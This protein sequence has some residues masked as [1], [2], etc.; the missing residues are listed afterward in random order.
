MA[1]GLGLGLL[2]GC[3]D[4]ACVFGSGTCQGGTGT[5][6]Q[7][8]VGAATTPE[9]GLW[10]SD[11]VPVV[12]AIFP[13]GGGIHPDTPVV[14]RFSESMNPS[15][16]QGAF[17]LID[18]NAIGGLPL[19][20]TSVLIGAGR[21]LVLF[22][23]VSLPANSDIQVVFQDSNEAR[24]L[25]GQPLQA[26]LESVVGSF[27]VAETEPAVPRL[28][29][30][31][32]PAG[33]QNASATTDI[34]AVFDR[35]MKPT[36]FLS[37]GWQVEV[38]GSPPV[39]DPTPNAVNISPLGGLPITDTRAWTYRR[40]DAA[41]G[42][43]L[44]YLN[45]SQ[46][47][48]LLS[49]SGEVQSIDDEVLPETVVNFRTA[50]FGAPLS[51][52]IASA[53]SDAIGI[54]NLT[55]GD[56]RA[57]ELSLLL[58]GAA[59][60]DRV[61]VFAFGTGLGDEPVT[62]ATQS[63]IDIATVS[64]PFTIGLGQTPLIESTSPLQASFLDGDVDL[65]F[66]VTRGSVVS[67]LRILD[68]DPDTPGVQ[69]AFLDT[70][71]PT[72]T[73]L[74]LPGGGGDL[75]S[76]SLIDLVLTGS[77]SEEV[78]AVNVTVSGYPNPEDVISN[79]DLTG[80]EFAPVV[81]STSGG[82]F[83]AAPVKIGIVDPVA[84]GKGG[85]GVPSV[86]YSFRVYDRAL[87]ANPNLISGLYRQFGAVAGAPVVQGDPIHVEVI[88]ADTL[89]P[90]PGAL[91]V[92]GGYVD[93]ATPASDLE[94]SLTDSTG[95]TTVTTKTTGQETVVTVEAAGYHLTSF[96]GVTT[97]WLGILLEPSGTA[98]A[99]VTGAVT[100]VS[101]SA[102]SF[103][104]N[105]DLR[106]A[107]SR[108]PDGNLPTYGAQ[109]CTAD[110][111]TG[112]NPNCA[113]GP[114][115]IRPRHLGAQALFVGSFG[116]SSASFSASEFLK[117]FQLQVPVPAAQPGGVGVSSGEIEKLLSTTETGIQPFELPTSLGT[118]TLSTAEIITFPTA[119]DYD[120]LVENSVFSGAVGV[121]VETRLPGLDRALPIGP[122]AS[123]D[124]S[125]GT[126]TYR[127]EGV[128]A[129]E[130]V[131][132]TAQFGD[133]LESSHLSVTMEDSSGNRAVARSR[134][135]Q[136]PNPSG[137]MNVIV[138]PI[139]PEVFLPTAGSDVPLGE[140]VVRF[141]DSLS[142]A[143]KSVYYADGP[144]RVR[145]TDVNG[146]HHTIYRYDDSD[147]AGDNP[148]ELD[149]LVLDTTAPGL[150]G[151]GTGLALGSI[152]IEVGY[153]AWESATPISGAPPAQDD[154]FARGRFL[155]SEVPLQAI[156]S[157]RSAPRVVGLV[158]PGP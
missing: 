32:P 47:S 20:T 83:I 131:P 123:F 9:D 145:L 67:P 14:V 23:A 68:V 118:L 66:R 42:L 22:P 149:V 157:T 72:F 58:D 103:L 80:A 152:S 37:T 122:G 3:D 139:V 75:F 116:L 25:T 64:N 31:W 33:E 96:H 79:M 48:L 108:R 97:D 27:T 107:D 129:G 151:T 55:A 92:A 82:L 105:A 70:V 13:T 101:Q 89:L 155:W 10:V 76:S 61:S 78:R 63:D 121:F 99:L 49:P 135:S 110:P 41:T 137:F 138:P 2:A 112:L 156:L 35:R 15:S 106:I 128:Y 91:V 148:T 88:D 7:L 77:A 45:G 8:G 111:F 124:I 102:Q 141:R 158:A 21:L 60:G 26:A 36:S 115:A 38:G 120:D 126:P 73:D 16:V 56:A 94:S 6:G 1:V 117:G 43:P 134:L 136:L 132:Y 87:N 69:S 12:E 93:A 11:N 98:P 130:L 143:Y 90:V 95:H 86:Q 62:V 144:Q 30:T 59:P 24:D 40:S 140:F 34:V 74:T 104:P 119:L 17:R 133:L 29:T 85:Y 84:D 125:V 146:R 53:P 127:I 57:L 153:S 52:S 39:P 100:A 109:P 81:G 154:A 4:P 147:S 5:T 65:A 51:A 71:R 150:A 18:A 44:S 46:I 54:A 114:E 142:F 19:A 113:F 28:L 50:T